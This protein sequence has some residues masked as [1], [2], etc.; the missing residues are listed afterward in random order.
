MLSTC[1]SANPSKVGVSTSASVGSWPSASG[2]DFASR[3][4]LW[5]DTV[6]SHWEDISH[7]AISHSLQPPSSSNAYRQG[8][9]SQDQAHPSS[10]KYTCQRQPQPGQGRRE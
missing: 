1:A 6:L 8:T 3:S 9:C 2:S 5:D 4:L 10:W 7:T